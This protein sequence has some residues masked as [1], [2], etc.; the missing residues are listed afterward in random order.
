[1]I[2]EDRRVSAANLLLVVGL[3]GHAAELVVE[4]PPW[5]PWDE[6]WVTPGWHRFLPEVFPFVA[7]GLLAVCGVVLL[8]R[9]SRGAALAVAFAYAL[10]HLTWPLR[11]RN[12]M[13]FLLAVYA[14]EA[15]VW[16][17]AGLPRDLDQRRAVDRLLAGGLAGVLVVTYLAAG[18]HKLNAA[19][20]SGDPTLSSGA[21]AARQFLVAGGLTSPPAVV[22]AAAP[23][24]VV[25]CELTLPLVA[26]LVGPLRRAAVLALFAFHFPM[27]SAMG[28]S[29]YPMLV[30]AL[31]P[32]L[33]TADEWS[34]LERKLYK[35]S[36]GKLAGTLAAVVLQARFVRHWGLTTSFGAVVAALW[37]W[38]SVALL[39][40]RGQ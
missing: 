33:F 20:L 28:V 40:R 36:L 21:L 30:S 25:A 14:L 22:V 27:I 32:A 19:F 26:W 13:S 38:A 8:W 15:G 9:R 16:L 37:G 4:N 31:Y 11:I 23:Y 39:S 35:P 3:A 12:H 17:A 6:R 24:A 10:H 34:D 5:Q 1:M 29:D 18:I 2:S 7:A